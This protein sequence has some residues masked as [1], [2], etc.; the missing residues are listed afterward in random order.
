MKISKACLFQLG[1]ALKIS[2]SE[3][4]KRQG[5]RGL[6]L[7]FLVLMLGCSIQERSRALGDPTVSAKTTALQVCSNCH[8]VKGISISPNFPNLAGQSQPYLVTQLK[9]FRS[10]GRSDPAGFEYMWGIS[11][12]LTDDQINGLAD[13]Y[14]TQKPS[15]GI[16]HHSTLLKEGQQIFEQGIVS[17]NV[18]ACSTCHGV[19]G[20]GMQQFPRIAGQHTDYTVKQLMVFQQTDQRPEGAIMKAITHNLT[21]ENM[22]SVALYLESMPSVK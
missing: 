4:F 1:D 12:R 11:A 14:S 15:T 8:G 10:H 21:P 5:C 22:K 6:I 3:N 19:N 7:T 18:A 2:A 13:Y 17:N 16:A 20:E 9:T